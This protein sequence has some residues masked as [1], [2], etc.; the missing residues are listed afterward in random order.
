MPTLSLLSDNIAQGTSSSIPFD[1]LSL[2][3]N[4]SISEFHEWIHSNFAF[5]VDHFNRVC[6]RQGE[7]SP[8]LVQLKSFEAL[9]GT[10]LL[11]NTLKESQAKA[12]VLA[13]SL[14]ADDAELISLEKSLDT[15]KPQLVQYMEYVGGSNIL[16]C[17]STATCNLITDTK[18]SR[19]NMTSFK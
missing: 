8:Q 13:D 9:L 18:A 10:D 17:V 15:L 12:L 2:E 6:F 11:A 14:R 16:Y 1:F 3:Y 5:N 7:N 19:R 4:F